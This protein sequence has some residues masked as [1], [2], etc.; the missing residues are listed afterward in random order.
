VRPHN[1][2]SMSREPEAPIGRGELREKTLTGVKWTAAGRGFIELFAFASTIVL[3][4]LIPPAEYGLA[5]VAF[6]VTLIAEILATGG[7]AAALVQRKDL[8]PEHY[9]FASLLATSM[10]VGLTVVVWLG[11]EALKGPVDADALWLVQLAS[12]SFLLSGPNV[13]AQAKLERRLDF[14]RVSVIGMVALA[15]GTVCSIVLA[16]LGLEGEALIIGR[17]VT[18]LLTSALSVAVT[19]FVMPG[20]DREAAREVLHVSLPTAFSSL[21]YQGVRNVDYVI[22]AAKLGAAQVGFYWRAFQLAAEYQGKITVIMTRLALPVYSRSQDLVHMRA[23]RRRIMRLHSTVIFPILAFFLVFA[24]VLIPFLYGDPWAPA[25]VPAQLLAVAGIVNAVSAGAGPML[26]A[27][28][29]A[30]T[31]AVWNAV[32]LV[33]YAATVW[34]AASAGGLVTVCI[35]ISA[36]YVVHWL[37]FNMIMVDRLVGIPLRSALGE[38]APA[39]TA[40]AALI[41]VAWPGFKLLEAAGVPVAVALVMATAAGSA[42]YLAVL[43]LAFPTAWGDVTLVASRMLPARLRPRAAAAPEP[44]AR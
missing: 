35:A 9:A 21:A 2:A 27:A 34:L 37:A 7:V 22:I 33:G 15:V 38:I 16:V 42:A 29:H 36:F 18:A 31:L 10:G 40:A 28:G 12:L 11:A 44:V 6:A 25:V 24:P 43:R 32:Q 26:V 41:A 1:A 39:T 30:R 19:G 5:A 8:R 20:W 13:V 14:R 3:A 23:L 17:L 4:R